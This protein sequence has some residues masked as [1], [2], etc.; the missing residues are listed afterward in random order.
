M[1][2]KP[3]SRVSILFESLDRMSALKDVMLVLRSSNFCA[4]IGIVRIMKPQIV[5]YTLC[6]RAKKEFVGSYRGTKNF[7][8]E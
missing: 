3:I 4:G 5:Y 2:D 1:S 7:N 8:D 6:E